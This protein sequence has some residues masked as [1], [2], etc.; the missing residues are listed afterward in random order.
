MRARVKINHGEIQFSSGPAR[1]AFFDRNEGKDCILE[2]DDAPTA[3]ARRYFEGALVPAVYYQHPRSG[4]IDFGDAREALKLEFL[5]GYTQDLHGTRTKIARSTTELS[6]EGFFKLTETITRWLIEN[7]MDAPDPDDYKVWR[8][9]A[10]PAGEVYPP[11][12][13]MKAT[14]DGARMK[15]NPWRKK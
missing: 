15:D 5:P 11:L 10:P 3:N 13:R 9:S 12:A 8:D 7:A 14:Y 4:W 2:V 6:K 1:R